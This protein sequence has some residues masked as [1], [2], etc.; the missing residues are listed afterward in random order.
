MPGFSTALKSLEQV[1]KSSTSGVPVPVAVAPI[2]RTP[3]LVVRVRW[4]RVWW[5]LDM[6]F[7]CCRSGGSPLTNN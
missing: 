1:Y 6:L 4:I 5:C 7:S 2:L 3:T